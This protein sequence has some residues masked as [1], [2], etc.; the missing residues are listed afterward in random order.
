MGKKVR[1]SSVAANPEQWSEKSKQSVAYGFTREYRDINYKC[2]HCKADC[3]F[4]AQDQQYTFEVKKASIDQRRVLCATC[5]TESHRIRQAI[6]D[7]ETL[8][9][10]EKPQRMG[11]KEFLSHWSHLLAA[12]ESYV[13][14]RP[15]T[16]KKNM[17]AKLLA[18][19]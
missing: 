12:L 15:D 8:W 2:W 4:T 13:P 3:V 16:A 6:R 5:W 7:C 9:A 1:P 19:T 10:E 17:L 18:A 14:Y 11:D